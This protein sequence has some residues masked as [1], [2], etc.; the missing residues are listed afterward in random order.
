MAMTTA[1]AAEVRLKR[2]LNYRKWS[3]IAKPASQ[4]LQVH[5]LA[6]RGSL[7]SSLF[8]SGHVGVGAVHNTSPHPQL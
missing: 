4:L 2:V 6:R 5:R 1:S 8:R 7:E 3:Q